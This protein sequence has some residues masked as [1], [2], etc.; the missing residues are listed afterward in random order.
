MSPPPSKPASR[1]VKVGKLVTE[2]WPEG[3]FVKQVVALLPCRR[4]MTASAAVPRTYRAHYRNGRPCAFIISV[5]SHRR[6]VRQSQPG[7]PNSAMDE[8]QHSIY[9]DRFRLAFHT[10]RG[11]AF[12]DWFVRLAEY[13][14]GSDFDTW[15]GSSTW[16]DA[17]FRNDLLIIGLALDE[18]EVFIQ[19]RATMRAKIPA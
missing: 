10:Q 11:T 3:E 16:L 7:Q 6:S 9:V 12:Q 14:F 4:A 1:R 18:V 15:R 5:T 8:L 19:R 13:A 17:I 2:A